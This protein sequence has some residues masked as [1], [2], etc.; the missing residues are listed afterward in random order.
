MLIRASIFFTIFIAV[1]QIACAGDYDEAAATPTPAPTHTKKHYSFPF[2]GRVYT[3]QYIY[4]SDSKSGNIAQ[5]SLSLWL[6]LDSRTEKGMGARFIGQ[7]DFF[8]RDVNHPDDVSVVPQL[9]EGYI[10]FLG[11]GS[12]LRVG[13]QIIPWGKSDG[14]NPTDYFT[15]KNYT[16]LNPDDEVRRVG[17]PAFNYS[18]TPSAGTSPFT[19]QFVFQ[20]YNPQNK[21]LIPGQII[22]AGVTFH[23]DPRPPTAFQSDSMEYGVKVA[24]QK[25]NFDFS[26]SAF[27][28]FSAYPEYIFNKTSFSIE[29]INAEETAVGGDC[30]FNFGE[31]IIRLESALH[32][33]TN[34]TDTDPLFGFVEPWHWDSVVGIERPF[35]DDFRF[36][37]QFLYRWH[38]Y[39]QST[40]TSTDPNPLVNRLMLGI[41]QANATLLNYQQRS[42]PG[43]S[44]RLSFAKETSKWTADVF[45]VG[46]FSDGTDF[47]LRPQVGFTPIEGFKLLTGMDLYGGDQ[48]RPLGSLHA[49]S[50]AF[51]EAKYLF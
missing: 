40:P 48:S 1:S 13:Q 25:S 34:G 44:L 20:A 9:R 30:S 39:Y 43:T 14:I 26:L 49:N 15:A 5:S 12:D 18:F 36:Q 11:E 28:G 46:Y 19:F 42:E 51:F 27:K 50:D 32:M 38:L 6:D 21:I 4:T 29:A 10:S 23:R 16:L 33:P 3:D 17:A 8:Y 31:S 45:L 35:L 24:Y 37:I 7:S 2:T 22:P 47:L 41:A